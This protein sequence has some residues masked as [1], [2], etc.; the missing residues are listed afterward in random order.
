MKT[1]TCRCEKEDKKAQG[2]HILALLLVVLKRHHGSE[3]VKQNLFIR[4][5]RKLNKYVQV[6][7]LLTD[8]F[9]CL[10]TADGYPCGRYLLLSTGGK[11]HSQYSITR[12]KNGNLATHAGHA[13]DVTDTDQP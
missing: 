8:I 4:R 9:V 5:N 12:G 3:R 7:S 1:F 2:F 10:R 6:R 11:C 13:Y